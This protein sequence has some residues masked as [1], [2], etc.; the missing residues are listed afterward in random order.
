MLSKL[1]TAKVLNQVSKI[2]NQTKLARLMLYTGR[3]CQWQSGNQVGGCVP[4]TMQL[5]EMGCGAMMVIMMVMVVMVV[6]LAMVMVFFLVHW[7][8]LKLGAVPKC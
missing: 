6:L 5:I 8:R 1:N 7:T 4:G 2:P 3:Q